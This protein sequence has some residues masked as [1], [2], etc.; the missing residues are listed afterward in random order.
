MFLTHPTPGRGSG[1]ETGVDGGAHRVGDVRV[2]VP[3]VVLA[4]DHVSGGTAETWLR[5]IVDSAPFVL[6]LTKA[7]GERRVGALGR[8]R[9]SV[10]FGVGI[11]RPRTP[12]ADSRGQARRLAFL[13]RVAVVLAAFTGGVVVVLAP[14]V[15]IE[16]PAV[17]ALA[18][19]LRAERDDAI[20][21]LREG[22]R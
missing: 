20:A 9:L 1:R 2:F 3:P 18:S 17:R 8:R 15:W 4:N 19:L 14:V 21:H 5:E 10:L 22:R 11:V 13:H 7:R 16:S 12:V 6:R